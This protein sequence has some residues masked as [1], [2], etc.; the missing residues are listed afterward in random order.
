MAG[1]ELL[2]AA[3]AVQAVSSI[4]AG[5]N[6][7]RNYKAQAQALDYNA[8]INRDNAAR[9]SLEYSIREDQQRRQQ[10]IAIGRQ[11]AGIAESGIGTSGTALDLEEQS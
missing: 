1:P 6:Q 10:S 4:S 5:N 2:L 7:A 9:V 8:Q 3:A 11:R